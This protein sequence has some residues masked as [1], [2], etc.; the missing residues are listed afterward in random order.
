[1]NSYNSPTTK[2]LFKSTQIVWYVLSL[3]EIILAFRFVFKLTG[4]NPDA[5]FVNFIYSMTLPFITP[6]S[7]V[8]PAKVVES[9]ILEWGTVLAMFVYW[10]IAIAI[11]KLLLIG[12]TVSTSEAASELD[13]QNF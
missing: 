9:G 2:S 13:R 4:A 3:L 1:M 5:G 7:A 11:I 10:M 6:F 8:F 12:K